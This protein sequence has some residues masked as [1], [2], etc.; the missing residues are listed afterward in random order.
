MP[1]QP[2]LTPPNNIR[3]A[4]ILTALLAAAGETE[5]LDDVNRSIG[6]TYCIRTAPD[7]P[8]AAAGI[9]TRNHI[10][11]INASCT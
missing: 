5:Q 8:C 7:S 11:I 6:Q 10:V 9:V 2:L 4:C 3:A 1:N